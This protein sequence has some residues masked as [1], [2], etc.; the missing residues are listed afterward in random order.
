MILLKEL[1][2]KINKNHKDKKK[3]KFSLFLC[4]FCKNGMEQG[5]YLFVMNG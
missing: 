2:I 5:V 4:P 3:M 1:G